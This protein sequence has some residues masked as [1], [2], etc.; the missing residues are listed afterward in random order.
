ML[1]KFQLNRL[2][3]IHEVAKKVDDMN[4]TARLK[5]SLRRGFG[6]EKDKPRLIAYAMLA[7]FV[8]VDDL[9]GY[10]NK[11]TFLRMKADLKDLGIGDTSRL[12]SLSMPEPR[13]DYWDYKMTFGGYHFKYI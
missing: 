5:N 7:Q 2:L 4:E 1:H 11:R 3:S 6:K 13:T 10:M 8:P 9:K 12:N